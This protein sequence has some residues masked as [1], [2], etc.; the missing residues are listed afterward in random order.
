MGWLVC[1]VGGGVRKRQVTL[2]SSTPPVADVTP[3]GTSTVY[4]VAMGKRSI[5]STSGSK[6]RVLVP[7]QRQWPGTSGVR[8]TGTSSLASSAWLVRET[9]GWEKVTLRLGAMGTSPSGE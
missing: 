5:P 8:I 4:S 7:T 6:K 9:M 1:R 2:S 3:A